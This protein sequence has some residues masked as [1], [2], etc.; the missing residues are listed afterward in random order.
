MNIEK[1]ET[2]IKLFVG[3]PNQYL[4]NS[5]LDRPVSIQSSTSQIEFISIAIE[6]VNFIIYTSDSLNGQITALSQDQTQQFNL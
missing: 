6:Y 4:R 3:D 1:Q 5:S 2:S